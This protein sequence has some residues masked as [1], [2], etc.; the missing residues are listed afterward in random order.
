MLWMPYATGFIHTFL[1]IEN[2]NMIRLFEL[3]LESF[4][5]FVGVLIML[6]T[7]LYYGCSTIVVML[8]LILRASTIRKKGYPPAHCDGD[9]DPIKK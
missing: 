9:G 2:N 3:A 1:E 8:Q 6:L 4:W 5:A 7:I